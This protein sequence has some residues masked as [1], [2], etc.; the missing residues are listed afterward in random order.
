MARNNM[1]VWYIFSFAD[2]DYREVYYFILGSMKLLLPAVVGT[3]C[4]PNDCTS[5]AQ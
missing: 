2:I 3:Y 5:S 1:T 4:S